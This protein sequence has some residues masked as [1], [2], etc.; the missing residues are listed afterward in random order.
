MYWPDTV[1]HARDAIERAGLAYDDMR[2]FLDR[3]LEAGVV[4][5]PDHVLA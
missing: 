1:P 4:I 2:P 5:D 3:A